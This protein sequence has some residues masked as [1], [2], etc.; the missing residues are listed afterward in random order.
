MPN[1]QNIS[2]VL[3]VYNL[4]EF[5]TLAALENWLEIA[6]MNGF[7]KPFTSVVLIGTHLDIVPFDVRPEQVQQAVEFVRTKIEGSISNWRGC[8]DQTYVSNL[9]GTGINE[10]KRDLAELVCMAQHL[11]HGTK[12]DC[13]DACAMCMDRRCKELVPT[14]ASTATDIRQT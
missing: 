8:I 12:P 11:R 14:S 9:T 7:I 4:S 2:V 13:D 1:M 10:L 5:R 3:L 6:I